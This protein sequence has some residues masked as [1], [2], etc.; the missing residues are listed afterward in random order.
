VYNV[1][2]LT[3]D[4]SPEPPEDVEANWEDE[5]VTLGKCAGT[6]STEWRK[7]IKNTI[8]Q[9]RK[10]FIAFSL[11]ITKVCFPPLMD[12]LPLAQ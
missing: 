9:V 8:A 4:S 7:Q 6:P 5:Q 12:S 10:H 3:P 11:S 1:Y 2:F